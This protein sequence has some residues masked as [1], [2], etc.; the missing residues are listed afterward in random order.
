MVCF[1]IIV[2]LDAARRSWIVAAFSHGIQ[3]FWFSFGKHCSEFREIA[4]TIRL[5]S[6]GSRHSIIAKHTILE[7]SD[8]W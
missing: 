3:G 6:A 1:A 2:C 7:T 8:F 5:R 4:A